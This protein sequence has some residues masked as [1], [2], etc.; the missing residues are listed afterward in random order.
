MPL[1][2]AIAFLLGGS[3]S[4]VLVGGWPP[5]LGSTSAGIAFYIGGAIVTVALVIVRGRWRAKRPGA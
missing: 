4:M 5:D 2:L 3:L 1:E